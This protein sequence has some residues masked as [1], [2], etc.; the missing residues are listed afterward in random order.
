M[1]TDKKLVLQTRDL[2]FERGQKGVD[3]ARQLMM[4]EKIPYAPLKVAIDY[5]MD[6]WKDVVHPALLSLACEAVGKNPETTVD[7]AAAFVLLAGGADLH[8]DIIDESESKDSEPTVFGKF[9][10]A[11]TVLAGD[12]LLFK[13]IYTLH[14]ACSVLP[15][16]K[17][18][19]ILDL[20]KQAFFGISSAEAK[21]TTLREKLDVS[22]EYLEMIKM[23]SAVSEATMKIGAILGDG[24]AEEVKL[25]GDFGKNFGV[26]FT[27]RDEFIDILDFKE[28]ETRCKKECWP[29]PIQL[30][31]KDSSKQMDISRVIGRVPLTKDDAE[32]LFDMVIDLK[33]NV[34]LK[35]EMHAIVKRTNNEIK[36]AKLHKKNCLKLLMK[37]MVEDL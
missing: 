1:A 19:Q 37:S 26:L 17:K 32:Q 15:E 22:E 16:A 24:S 6:S 12:A 7:V 10:R 14:E 2:L 3:K 4:Q 5:F 23:K 9:G 25:M 20:T 36:L 34:K 11:F 29:L 8:D 28:L 33:E 13:G 21:E 35:N 31:L 18:E 30:A 27:L